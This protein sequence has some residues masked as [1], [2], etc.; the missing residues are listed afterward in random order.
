MAVLLAGCAGREADR[1]PAPADLVFLG[2]GVYTVD[3]GRVRAEAVAVRG[4]RITAVGSDAEV[5]AWIGPLTEVVSLE[6]RMLLPGFHDAHIHPVTAGLDRLECPLS[7]LASVEAILDAVRDCLAAGRLRGDWLVGSGWDVSLFPDGNAPR[8]PLDALAPRTPVVLHDA[9]GHAVWVNGA[10]LERAGVDARTPDPEAGVIER[11]PD[12]G[13]PSGTLRETAAALVTRR[14]PAPT[15]AQWALAGRLAVETL[16]RV[17]VTSVL[18]ARVDEAILAAYRTLS[19]RGELDLHV[20]GCIDYGSGFDASHDAVEALLARR[21]DYRRSDVDPD[22]VKLFVDGVLEGET[23]ALLDPYEGRPGYRG[24]PNFDESSLRALVRR[25]DAEGLQLHLHAIGDAAVRSALDALEAAREAN[26]PPARRPAIA[27]LQLVHPDDV[28]RFA[29]LGVVADFQPV[30]AWPDEYVTGL[31]L[32]V[33]GEARLRWMYPIGGV[34]RSG[35]RL[36]MG[37]DWNVSPP[38]ALPGIEVSVLRRDPSGSVAG[39]LNPEQAIDLATAIEAY[40]RGGA[41]LMHRE[42]ETGSIA[43]GMRADL[44][45]LERDLFDVPPERISEVR[46]LRTLVAGRTVFRVP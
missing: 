7:E 43:V 5:R 37:T 34:A 3:P 44:V 2:G 36:A 46:V 21:G 32:P 42:D 41:T 18:D 13:E 16:H 33:I 10:A 9:N 4:G 39:V 1:A 12:T 11:D 38:D 15:P 23:A 20:V 26:G 19:D 29:A 22:C 8:A 27:H 45:V 17:G 6:G 28:G 35:A 40:T 30:W 31:N 24:E 25:F 14:V